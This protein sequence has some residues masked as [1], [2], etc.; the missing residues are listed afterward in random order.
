MRSEDCSDSAHDAGDILSHHPHIVFVAALTDEFQVSVVAKLRN[1]IVG[2]I[3]LPLARHADHIAH[4]S[5]SGRKRAGPSAIEH[6]IVNCVAGDKH[7]IEFIADIRQRMA[8]RNERRLHA[9]G[10]LSVLLTGTRKQLDLISGFL[11]KGDVIRFNVGDALCRNL[12]RSYT[13]TEYQ[14]YQNRE[15]IRRI[16]SLHISGRVCLR[17]ALRLCVPKNIGVILAIFFHLRQDIIR[18]SIQD[19]VNGAEFVGQKGSRQGGQDRNSACHSRFETE[20]NMVFL[21][22]LRKHAAI[23][24]N[25]RL[26]CRDNAL[27]VL[28]CPCHKRGGWLNT[29]D[30]FH[31]DTDLR[32]VQ[33][34][35]YIQCIFLAGNVDSAVLFRVTVQNLHDFNIQSGCI[36]DLFLIHGKCLVGSLADVADSKHADFYFFHDCSP[37]PVYI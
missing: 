24:G 14:R 22:E 29:S 5:A 19:A 33:D 30:Q 3:L 37:L 26:V 32:I 1:D 17:E 27:A 13:Q 7:G 12:I 10:N 15:L 9:G 11:C 34:V 23:C 28:E 31:D 16:N 18:C 20:Q 36:R 21:C 2:G 8:D 6:Q 4:D 35:I 25:C